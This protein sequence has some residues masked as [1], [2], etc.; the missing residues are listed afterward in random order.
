MSPEQ[1]TRPED[2]LSTRSLNEKIDVYA[3]GNILFKITVGNSPWK[4]RDPLLALSM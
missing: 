2:D 1:Q 4:V 3:L